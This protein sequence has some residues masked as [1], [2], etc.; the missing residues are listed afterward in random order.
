M[1][2][3]RS[4][5]AQP[6]SVKQRGSCLS[7]ILAIAATVLILAMLVVLTFGYFGAVIALA[8][9]IFALA[10]LHYLT[11]GW[12]LSRMIHDEEAAKRGGSGDWPSAQPRRGA[13][14]DNHDAA[15]TDDNA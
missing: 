9:G 15:D 12:W 8:A 6:D 5:V 3:E 4:S 2:R 7:I 13:H 10:A 14:A 1:A 11:W